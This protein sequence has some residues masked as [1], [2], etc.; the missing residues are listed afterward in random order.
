VWYKS[1]GDLKGLS[2]ELAHCSGIVVAA[3]IAAILSSDNTLL[4]ESGS[5]RAVRS[6]HDPRFCYSVHEKRVSSPTPC[7]LS[8]THTTRLPP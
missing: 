3:D 2:K 8:L 5:S 4:D 7:A 6:I 1:A